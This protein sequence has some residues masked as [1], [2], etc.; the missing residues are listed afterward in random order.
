[1][2]VG[3]NPHLINLMTIRERQRLDTPAAASKPEGARGFALALDESVAPAPTASAAEAKVLAAAGAA[4]ADAVRRMAQSGVGAVNPSLT[5]E[6]ILSPHSLVGRFLGDQD[7]VLAAQRA[8][9]SRY[10]NTPDD[11]TSGERETQ[12]NL[13]PVD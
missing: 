6:K 10:R 9:D 13:R 8:P 11:D 5:P 1:M 3:L 2:I 7:L 4:Q 12:A